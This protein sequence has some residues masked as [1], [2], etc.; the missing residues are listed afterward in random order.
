[1]IGLVSGST[2][3]PM[4]AIKPLPPLALYVHLPWCVSKCPYCDFNSHAL[5]GALPT[6]KYLSA[7]LA[8]LELALAI[9][10]SRP[11]ETVF[12]G[13]GTPSLFPASEISKVLDRLRFAGRLARAAEITLEAN[14]GTVERHS[15][16]ELA[17]AGITR[18][19][20]GAQSF[21]PARL[22]SLGR[23][24]G[25]AETCRAA[26]EL[27]AAGLVNFNIDLMFALPG[28][29]LAGALDDVALAVALEPA[30]ISHYQLTIEP[31]TAFHRHP[32]QLPP[33]DDAWAMQS[34]CQELLE[35]SGFSQYEVSAFARTG[36]RCRHN[37]NY[38]EY[39]DYLG[40]GAGA[41]EK[42]TA[43][44]GTITRNIRRSHPSHYMRDAGN[45]LAIATATEVAP[46]ERI[47]EFMLN[48]L[49]LKS[50]FRMDLFEHRTGLPA[51]TLLPGLVAA[52]ER[53]LAL[54]AEQHWRASETGWRFL[55]DLQAMFLTE[56]KA[57]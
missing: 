9:T 15:F 4:N 32:P 35:D 8:D 52:A 44:D 29:H 54:H 13:G 16:S 7:L 37:M 51:A 49:R 36:S 1:M 19:S 17:A 40:I 20:L 12:F 33:E 46:G 34:E 11:I 14:P 50:G 5:S 26:E 28:Q 2:L 56:G 43:E 27:H 47:F 55:N 38:W 57:A 18:I 31:R 41:H 23:I 22:K 30:H 53:G 39:G 42:L 10:G 25:P 45:A 24:H 48:A 6:G 3:M 21:D